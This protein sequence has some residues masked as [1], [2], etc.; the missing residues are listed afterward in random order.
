VYASWV[1]ARIAEIPVKHHP[2]IMGKSKYGLARTIKVLFDLMTI[3]FMSS[4]QTK[5]IYVFASFGV[6]SFVISLVAVLYTLYRLLRGDTNIIISGPPV[7][8]IVAFA[9]GMQSILL[10]LIAEVLARTYHESQ[11]KPIYIIREVIETPPARAQNQK[12]KN[13]ARQNLSG[14]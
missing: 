11:A 3:K 4:Y 12:L 13:Y 2:R 10:G 8:A 7:I 5:P 1:G 6:I 14:F 9:L